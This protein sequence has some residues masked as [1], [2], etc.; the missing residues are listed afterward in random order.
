[1]NR[2]LMIL[3]PAIVFP[4]AAAIVG[5]VVMILFIVFRLMDNTGAHVCGMAAVQRSDYAKQ[6]LGTP[7]AQTGFTGGKS[8]DNNGELIERITF[9]VSGPRG[10]AFVLSE[11]NRSP[12]ESRLVVKMGREGQSQTIYSGPFD[13]PELHR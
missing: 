5:L 3:I 1:M 6:L 13:C 11:G 4:V 10:E 9:T 2:R 8:Q 7:I 12:L